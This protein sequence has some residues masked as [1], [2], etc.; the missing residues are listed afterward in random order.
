MPALMDEI[1]GIEDQI[2]AARTLLYGDNIKSKLDIGAPP[3]PSGRM[4]W[5][6]YEQ[7]HSTSNITDTHRSSFAI[8]KEEFKPILKALNDLAVNEVMALE[9]KL[10]DADAPYTPGRAIRMM[11][12]Y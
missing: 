9:K 5:I 6:S 7:K 11:K 10:E 1:S 3:T 2:Q 12:G 8:A 4:G